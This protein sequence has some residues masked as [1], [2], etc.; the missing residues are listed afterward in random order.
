[1]SDDKKSK[2]SIPEIALRGTIIAA[3]ITI[4]SIIT[5]VITWTI[6]DNLVYAAL[7]GAVV[8]FVT[9]GFSLK[10]S[11]KILVKK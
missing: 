6:L 11:K 9:M 2:L 1:L 10:I 7:L 3:I 4:P 8:H 5:F